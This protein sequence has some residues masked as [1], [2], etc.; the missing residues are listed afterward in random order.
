MPTRHAFSGQIATARHGLPPYVD[1]QEAA[2]IRKPPLAVKHHQTEGFG[3]ETCTWPWCQFFNG[4][5]IILRHGQRGGNS[6]GASMTST[7]YAI[8]ALILASL[9]ISPPVL[10]AG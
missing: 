8:V 3:N 4:S 2:L 7:R 1:G 6:L 5:T 9:T 10:G